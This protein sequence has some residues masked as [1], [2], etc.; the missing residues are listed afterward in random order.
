MPAVL[1]ASSRDSGEDA[2]IYVW[3]KCGS[4]TADISAFSMESKNNLNLVHGGFYIG[5]Y[6][7]KYLGAKFT[8]YQICMLIRTQ[9]PCGVTIGYLIKHLTRPAV[10]PVLSYDEDDD[11]L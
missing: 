11:W 5:V 3:T 2:M 7:S 8:A 10:P 6:I 9:K 4:T 1:A